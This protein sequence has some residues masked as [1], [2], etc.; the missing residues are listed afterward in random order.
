MA[1]TLAATAC[2]KTPGRDADAKA[3]A[4]AAD[5]RRSAADASLPDGPGPG[6]SGRSLDEESA[7]FLPPPYDGLR[8]GAPKAVVLAAHPAARPSPRPADPE[9][10]DWYRMHGDGGLQ[11]LLG[12][13]R[14]GGRGG[15][16]LAGVQFLSLLAFE[17]SG[18]AGE[19][20]PVRAAEWPASAYEPHMTALRERYGERADVYACPSGGSFPVIRVVWRGE[21]LAVTAAFLMHEKG[22][23]STLVVTRREATDRY[24]RATGCTW[25][26]D[27]LM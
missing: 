13:T 2:G 7:G 15:A 23:S 19:S 27:R 22:L 11:V 14:E 16:A 1:C 20:D 4:F 18:P 3:E 24:L 6:S 10:L 25:M 21:S 9:R 12:F 17:R 26:Q 8:I 5:S